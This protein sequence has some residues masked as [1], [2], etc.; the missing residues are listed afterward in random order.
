[1]SIWVAWVE[2]ECGKLHTCDG[3]SQI[4]RCT[5][6]RGLYARMWTHGMGIPR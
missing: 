6:G 1:M 2:C 5:C 4:S 3:I